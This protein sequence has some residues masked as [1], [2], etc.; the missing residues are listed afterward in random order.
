MD[1]SKSK[2]KLDESKTTKNNNLYCDFDH[3][4]SPCSDLQCGLS[5]DQYNSCQTLQQIDKLSKKSYPSTI[6]SNNHDETTSDSNLSDCG[7][8][9]ELSQQKHLDLAYESAIPLSTRKS[10]LNITNNNNK[11]NKKKK[12]KM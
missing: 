7:S 5:Q 12:Q 4:A 6:I 8:N 10:L 9:Y 2:N 1:E 3:P 11:K